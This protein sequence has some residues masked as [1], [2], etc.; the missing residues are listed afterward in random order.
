MDKSISILFGFGKDNEQFDDKYFWKYI[1]VE[2]WR[3]RQTG[4]AM[5]ACLI[6]CIY[7]DISIVQ[8]NNK[9]FC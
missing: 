9:H 6:K 3:I 1:R 2:T 5:E 4:D 8:R 7:I